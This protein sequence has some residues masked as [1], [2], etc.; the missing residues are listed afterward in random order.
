LYIDGGASISMTP[1]KKG[2][3]NYRRE[4]KEQV[5]TAD[6]VILRW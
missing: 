1:F 5:E 4:A 6:G 2:L 3:R